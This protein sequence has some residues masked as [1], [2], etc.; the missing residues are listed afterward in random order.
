MA[1]SLLLCPYLPLIIAL[2]LLPAALFLENTQERNNIAY[3]NVSLFLSLFF[4]L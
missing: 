1:I 4:T 2:L 3:K